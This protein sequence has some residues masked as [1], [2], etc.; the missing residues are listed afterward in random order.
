MV[1]LLRHPNRRSVVPQCRRARSGGSTAHRGLDKG[2]RA[3]AAWAARRG[4]SRGSRGTIVRCP[5]GGHVDAAAAIV[6]RPVIATILIHLGP[7][8]QPPPRAKRARSGGQFARFTGRIGS[9]CAGRARDLPAGKLTP[10]LSYR[11]ADIRGRQWTTHCGRTSP[12]KAVAQNA[13][14]I[15]RVTTFN[16]MQR[17]MH[18]RSIGPHSFRVFVQP[19]AGLGL[20]PRA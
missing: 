4:F 20:A 13:H 14:E 19:Q 2:V 5:A 7:D 8:P 1:W 6:A 12:A 9:A 11:K 18:G 16:P 17:S 15:Q 3:A 10:K